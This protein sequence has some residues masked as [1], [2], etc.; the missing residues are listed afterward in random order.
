MPNVDFTDV[1][2]TKTVSFYRL[3]ARLSSPQT[4]SIQD[5]G[6]HS[7]GRDHRSGIPGWQVVRDPGT[8]DQNYVSCRIGSTAILRPACLKVLCRVMMR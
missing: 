7:P 1:F 4:L 2:V 6:T 5:D 3:G 8:G